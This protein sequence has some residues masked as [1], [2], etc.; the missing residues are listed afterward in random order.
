MKNFQ[1][2][3]VILAIALMGIFL[4]TAENLPDNQTISVSS[5]HL[6]NFAL[7]LQIGFVPLLLINILCLPLFIFVSKFLLEKNINS[8]N[9]FFFGIAAICGTTS[10]LP[11]AG[12]ALLLSI[13]L[14][15]IVLISFNNGLEVMFLSVKYLLFFY[16][17]TLTFFALTGFG[18]I[19]SLNISLLIGSIVALALEYLKKLLAI[20]TII[21]LVILL[22]LADLPAK[23]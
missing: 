22:I 3:P 5:S 6:V 14:F 19:F 23:N 2:L 9:I 16:F 12:W 11:T 15:F 17:T 4:T 20:I 8:E 18:I 21:G 13:L 7:Q 1:T 10:A